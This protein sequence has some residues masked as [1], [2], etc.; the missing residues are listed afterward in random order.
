VGGLGPL[1]PNF[2]CQKEPVIA[3][4]V[5]RMATYKWSARLTKKGFG[6]NPRASTWRCRVTRHVKVVKL[7]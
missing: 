4:L 6:Q 3:L 2:D 7:G 5:W 1:G